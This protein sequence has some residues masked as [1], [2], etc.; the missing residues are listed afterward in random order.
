M[1]DCDGPFG[2][3]SLRARLEVVRKHARLR[4]AEARLCPAL[5]RIKAA[6]AM[7]D[8][9]SLELPI[10]TSDPV[11]TVRSSGYDARLRGQEMQRPEATPRLSAPPLPSGSSP[12]A[13][14]DEDGHGNDCS[15]ELPVMQTMETDMLS[16][17]ERR[18]MEDALEEISAGGVERPRSR[19]PAQQRA[20]VSYGPSLI[21]SVE[22]GAVL[23]REAIRA[24]LARAGGWTADRQAQNWLVATD[25]HVGIRMPR[26][27]ARGFEHVMGFL[28]S[29]RG[30]AFY[31]GITACPVTR[32]NGL[33]SMP[34]HRLQWDFMT[35]VFEASSSSDTADLER[36]LIA[37]C[38]SLYPAMAN[39]GGGGERAGFGS[40]H[41]LYVL[42]R[43]SGLIRYSGNSSNRRRRT[44]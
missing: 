44:R 11:G 2:V 26:G 24:R 7:A 31:I 10:R 19:S 33:D 42:T 4:P 17:A 9:P 25:G 21:G 23:S 18:W 16:Q 30:T 27:E 12:S 22:D 8:T 13:F 3:Q 34:G 40:P 15:I 6:L 32:W 1:L 37:A 35:V 29:L 39:I 5:G 36:E 14:D 28:R 20:W 41:Y 38:R 43:A